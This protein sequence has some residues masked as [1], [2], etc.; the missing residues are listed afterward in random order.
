MKKQIKLGSSI[1]LLIIMLVYF[2][3]IDSENS[4]NNYIT[5]SVVAN[6]K[7]IEKVTE[8]KYTTS[9]SFR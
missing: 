5:D 3:G 2:S 4:K 8:Y 9:S 6:V 7:S 1:L